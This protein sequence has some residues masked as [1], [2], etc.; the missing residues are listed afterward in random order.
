MDPFLGEIRLFAGNFAPRGWAFCGGQLLSISQNTALFS[1]LGTSYG[2]DGRTT[3]GL[4]DLRGRVP[5]HEGQGPGL[6]RRDLGEQSGSETVTLLATE[7]PAHTHALAATTSNA[8]SQVARGNLPAFTYTDAV[9]TLYA[10]EDGGSVAMAPG[11]IAPSGSGLPHDNRM[12]TLALNFII[13]L[14]GVFPSRE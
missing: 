1:L 14:Q 2:G 12:P 8:T 9:T 6:T 3:F 7:L 11:A 5:V 10:N 13:A 4:P